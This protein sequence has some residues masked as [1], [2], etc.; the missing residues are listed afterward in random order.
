MSVYK[1]IMQGLDEAVKYQEG[2]IHARKTRISVKPVES[3]TSEDIK[4][5][6]NRLGLSQVI[7]ASSLGVSKKTVEAWERGKNT[8]EGPSRRL[9]QLIRDNPDMIEQ[10]MIKG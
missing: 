6:R 9:L 3:F 10:Y 4:Q 5:I 8:P 7:F 1:S 2:T